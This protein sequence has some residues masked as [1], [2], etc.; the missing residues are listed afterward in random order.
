MDEKGWKKKKFYNFLICIIFHQSYVCMHVSIL[1][2]FQVSMDSI[3]LYIC[4]YH[5]IH[6]LKYNRYLRNDVKVFVQLF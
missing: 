5:N 1:N 3:I 6:F 2:I 4:V